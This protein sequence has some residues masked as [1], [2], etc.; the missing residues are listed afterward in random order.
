MIILVN[1]IGNFPLNDDWVY[2]LA[3]KSV[4]ETG[5]FQLHSFSMANLGPQVYWGAL[6]CLPFGF[7]FTALRISTLVLGL[8]GII[9]LYVLLREFKVDTKTSL[10]GALTL[11]VNPLYFGLS[12]SFMTDVPFVSMV[13][14]AIY[15]L[16]RGLNEDS[17]RLI[18]VGVGVTFLAIL[19][20]QFG[21][22]VFLGFAI[23]YLLKKGFTRPNIAKVSGLV[24]MGALLHVFYQY[25]LIHSGRVPVLNI[26]AVPDIYPPT[27]LNSLKK[28]TVALI[29]IGFFVLPYV[30]AIWSMSFQNQA[31]KKIKY[32][33]WGSSIYI[34]LLLV[35]LWVTNQKLPLL[36]NIVMDSGLGPLTLKDTFNLKLNLPQIPVG[37]NYFWGVITF[38]SVVAAGI[39]LFFIGR[40]SYHVLRNLKLNESHDY[41]ASYA[42]IAVM[43]LSYLSILLVFVAR[44]TLF[45]RYFLLFVPLVLLLISAAVPKEKPIQKIRNVIPGILILIY[46][47]FSVGATH[48]FLEWN[49]TRWLALN[50]LTQV[51][52]ISPRKIDGGYEFNGWLLYDAKYQ[53][54]SAKSWWWVDDDEYV[55]SAGSLPG[56]KEFK[57]YPVKRWLKLTAAEVIVLRRIP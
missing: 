16:L 8:V 56:Y 42:F 55:L 32:I 5:H 2:A 31:Q 23:A 30:A 18:V 49:R 4:L 24:L 43:A 37:A 9:A 26:P 21:L 34:L 48:D 52:K 57:R 25:W 12:N 1:P 39:T 29:Y 6:F 7:S 45:D 50:E 20:R 13:L 54:S 51:N 10:L 38:L 17:L 35:F 33:W 44:Y 46:V 28:A 36:G 14:V 19:I 40:A 53:R 15:F 41:S 22:I 27:L 11:A 47:S 3:V